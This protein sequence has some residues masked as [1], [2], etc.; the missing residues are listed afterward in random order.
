MSTTKKGAAN[1]GTTPKQG[2]IHHRK[3]TTFPPHLQ[4][5]YEILSD[6]NEYSA[7]QINDLTGRNDARKAVSELKHDPYNMQIQG[8]TVTGQRYKKYR[9][10]TRNKAYQQ[11]ELFPNNNQGASKNVQNQSIKQPQPVGNIIAGEWAAAFM[12]RVAEAEKGG[13][14]E[15]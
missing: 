4:E 5:V 13:K 9:L 1:K 3:G 10:S 8:R 12:G 6:G 7:K 11:T 14:Y 15:K 2:S